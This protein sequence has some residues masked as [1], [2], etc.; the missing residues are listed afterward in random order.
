MQTQTAQDDGESPGPP[1]PTDW[2][3]AVLGLCVLQSLE[4]RPSYG[5]AIISALDA[6]GFGSVKGGTLYPLLARY[7]SAGWVATEW[8]AG[9]SGPGRKY[10]SLTGAGRDELARQRTAWGRFTATTRTYLGR[11]PIPAAEAAE[12]RTA[13][14]TTGEGTGR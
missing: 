9:T 14:P 1:W 10:F 6:A 11:S 12:P 3:R 13:F 5:Y 4:A 8:R 7:E 2:M